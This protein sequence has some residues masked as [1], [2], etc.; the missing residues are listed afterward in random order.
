MFVNSVPFTLAFKD[1]PPNFVLAMRWKGFLMT[2]FVSRHQKFHFDW[3]NMFLY[4]YFRKEK[5]DARKMPECSEKKH[6]SNL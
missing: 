1:F 4:C 6:E 2:S 5:C 3:F